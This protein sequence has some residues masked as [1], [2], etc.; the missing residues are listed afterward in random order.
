MNLCR[1][2]YTNHIIIKPVNIVLYME[3][4]HVSLVLFSISKRITEFRLDAFFKNGHCTFDV[5]R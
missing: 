5:A 4:L 2:W 3:A 1:T